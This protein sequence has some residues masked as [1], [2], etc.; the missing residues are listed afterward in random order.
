M[1]KVILLTVIALAAIGCCKNNGKCCK[2]AQAE[3]AAV[4]EVVIEE[5]AADSTAEV[6]EVVE[7]AE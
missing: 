6:V 3:E 5:V 4:E 2:E 7:V 1:K